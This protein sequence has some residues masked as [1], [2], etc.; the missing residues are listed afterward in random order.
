MLTVETGAGLADADSY[1]SV[2]G[3][4]AHC[5]RQG[6]DY[7]GYDDAAIE[8]AL[9]KATQWID[10]TYGP[11]FKGTWSTATQALQWPRVG[12]IYRNKDVDAYEI[13]SH[14]VAATSEATFRVLRDADALMP[15]TPAQAVKRDKVG[16]VETEFRTASATPSLGGFKVIDAFLADL[17][18][19]Q[20]K[21]YFGRSIRA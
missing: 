21:A 15:D 7:S 14:L 13:P 11:V 2:A 19:G 8:I 17:I 3:F 5:D 18:T 1:V 20:A 6:L 4:K 16:D 9:R 10:A 12:V